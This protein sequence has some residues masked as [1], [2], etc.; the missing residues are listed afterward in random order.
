MLST[1][2]WILHWRG[3]VANWRNF[4][5]HVARWTFTVPCSALLL[6]RESTQKLLV[7]FKTVRFKANKTNL[8]I[9]GHKLVQTSIFRFLFYFFL[10]FSP[11]WQTLR[12]VCMFL[13]LNC[14]VLV[15]HISALFFL[16][17]K[18]N[19]KQSEDLI[20]KQNT[21]FVPEIVLRL[22]SLS[23]LAN[24]E[25]E[26][27]AFNKHCIPLKYRERSS[28]CF[29]CQVWEHIW[30]DVEKCCELNPC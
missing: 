29:V 1:V 12:K 24:A 5:V 9:L 25:T 16:H 22:L 15:S 6:R 20:L 30:M 26:Q 23:F 28:K 27:T 10:V 8:H 21:D 7:M 3:I 19:N 2:L 17:I 14:V 11:K 18:Q 13:M 4:P